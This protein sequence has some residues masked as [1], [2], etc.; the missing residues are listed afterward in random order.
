MHEL[1]GLNLEKDTF[2]DNLPIRFIDMCEDMEF[3]SSPESDIPSKEIEEAKNVDA[4]AGALDEG[5]VEDAGR[6]ART[7]IGLIA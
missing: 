6:R 4:L 7:S 5:L 1:E 2:Y 3:T